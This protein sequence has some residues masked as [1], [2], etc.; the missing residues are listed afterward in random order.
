[1][2]RKYLFVESL[3]TRAPLSAKY[4]QQARARSHAATVSH[5]KWTF[6]PGTGTSAVARRT[7]DAQTNARN[8][9]TAIYHMSDWADEEGTE[10]LQTSS[11]QPQQVKRIPSGRPPPQSLL[12]AG[13]RDP[14]RTHPVSRHSLR[15]D[16]LFDFAVNVAAA[17]MFD[18]EPGRSPPNAI[19]T[20]IQMAMTDAAAFHAALAMFAS[21]QA[22]TKGANLSPE[23]DYHKVECVRMISGRLNGGSGP[24]DGTIYAVILLWAFES[25]LTSSEALQAHVNGLELMVKR[26]GGISTLTPEVQCMLAW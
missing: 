15:S 19:V 13:K 22:N 20:T 4:E 10:A 24:L 3:P 11:E 7:P 8:A 23:V 26:R 12:D 9:W 6:K 5:R 18:I 17:T 25:T 21:I 14:F 2:D 1:M 16:E